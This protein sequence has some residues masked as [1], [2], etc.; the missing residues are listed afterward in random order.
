[1][2]VLIAVLLV[3]VVVLPIVGWAL[4]LLVSAA[5]VGAIIGGLARLV[6]PGRQ[7]IGV[8]STIV[9]G[10]IGSLFGSL[11]GRHLFY[12]GTFLTVLCEIGVAA[13]LVALAS[14]GAGNAFA[15]RNNSLRR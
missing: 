15:R 2:V 14:S 7:A 9:I 11:I 3:L 1:M 8:F 5:L 4:W 6:L 10:W 13:I 12:V